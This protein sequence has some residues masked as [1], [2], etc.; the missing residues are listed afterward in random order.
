MDNWKD[1]DHKD[2][3]SL[4]ISVTEMRYLMSKPLRI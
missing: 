4:V 1:C 3:S 2:K